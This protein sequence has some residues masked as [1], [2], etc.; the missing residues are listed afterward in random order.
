VDKYW[1]N[2]DPGAVLE[3]NST[4]EVQSD[5]KRIYNVNKC[6][7]RNT[8][9]SYGKEYCETTDAQTTHSSE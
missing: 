3:V 8:V 4:V 2:K 6:P 1:E 9:L 7:S 5:C